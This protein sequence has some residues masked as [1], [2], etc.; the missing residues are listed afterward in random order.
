MALAF[1]RLHRF[2]EGNRYLIVQ[3]V[4]LDGSYASGGYALTPTQVGHRNQITNISTGVSKNGYIS[5]FDTTTQKLKFYKVGAAGALTEC[6]SG[7]L[8][9]SDY[10]ILNIWGK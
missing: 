5:A 6:V 2:A 8:S 4:T 1:T 7:D 3:Q 10:V 9:S